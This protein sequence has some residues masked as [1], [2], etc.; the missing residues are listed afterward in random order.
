VQGFSSWKT[1]K[2]FTAV[3][4]LFFALWPPEHVARALAAEARVLARRFGGKATRE[5]T[6]HMTLAFLGELGDE[7]LPEVIAVARRVRAEPFDLLVDRLGVWRHKRLIWAACPATAPLRA[8]AR[9]LRERLRAADV[10]C[11]EPGRF[12]PHLSLVR[13]A[14]D[15]PPELP[16]IEPLSW[17]CGGFALVRSRLTEAG[18]DYLDVAEFPCGG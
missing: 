18:P 12:V 13:R 8:L 4:R 2:G 5:E 9:D 14:G 10:A 16:A 3:M 11:D 17:P 7:R 1:V 6:V 15:M